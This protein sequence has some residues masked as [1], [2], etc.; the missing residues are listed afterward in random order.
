MKTGVLL[1]LSIFSITGTAQQPESTRIKELEQK[2]DHAT[3][4]LEQLNEA[5][6]ELRAEIAKL[7]GAAIRTLNRLAPQHSNRSGPKLSGRISPSAS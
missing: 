2:L 5:M 7:K 1:L 3:R 6:G 4:Q